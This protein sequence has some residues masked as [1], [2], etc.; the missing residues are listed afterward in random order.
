MIDEPVRPLHPGEILR[1]EFMLTH[2][3]SANAL[4][5][6]LG[7]TTARINEIAREQRGVTA[8]TALRLARF[9]STTAQFWMDLQKQY[10]LETARREVGTMIR[11]EV[12]PLEDL[13][14]DL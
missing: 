8:D 9:F 7:V 11:Q 3:L 12:T 14:I 5:G 10:E 13:G 6:H 4:A 2:S 1:E